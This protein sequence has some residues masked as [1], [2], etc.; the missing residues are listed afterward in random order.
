M[1]R[2][3]LGIVGFAAVLAVIVGIVLIARGGDDDA[4][5][6]EAAEVSTDLTEKPEPAIEGDPPTELVSEDIVEGD[7]AEAQ[8][9]DQVTVQYVGVDFATGEE[10][11]SSWGGEP[12]E[13]EL[14]GGDV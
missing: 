10:F 7:G 1:D 2:R 5:D 9:G 3:L 12:F 11:D 14:G 13:F 8:T 4:G 6:T